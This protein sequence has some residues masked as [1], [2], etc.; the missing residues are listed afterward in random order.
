VVR[1]KKIR[2]APEQHIAAFVTILNDRNASVAVATLADKINTL[3][4]ASGSAKREQGDR[5]NPGIARDLAVGRALVKL[6]HQLIR[7]G[8]ARVAENVAEQAEEQRRA[9]ARKVVRA[10][11]TPR[12]AKETTLL[13]TDKIREQYGEEAAQ[14]AIL[15]RRQPPQHHSGI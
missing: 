13:P 6:G 11:R 14:R 2:V 1:K 15:R 9:G 5:A 7:R 4:Q 3:G 8:T 10:L 12:H